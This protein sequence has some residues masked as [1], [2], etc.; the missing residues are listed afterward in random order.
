MKQIDSGADIAALAAGAGAQVKKAGD[1]HRQGGA[2]LPESVV[3]ALFNTPAGGAGSAAT[4]EGR[5][6]FKVIADATP[7]LDLADAKTKALQDKAGGGLTDDFVTQYIN[8]L[9]RE[10][11][12]TV[13]DSV[14]R[15][16][17]GG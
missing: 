4:Q 7:P 15:A 13:N 12:V 8:A 6:V 1:V 3:T 10:L 14:L 5:M 11:G 17:E 9:Q 2:S 16:A